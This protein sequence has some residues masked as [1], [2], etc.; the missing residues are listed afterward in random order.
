MSNYVLILAP[1]IILAAIITVIFGKIYDMVGFKR[2]VYPVVMILSAGYVVLALA[3][4]TVPVFIG[5]VLMMAGYLSGMAVF[6][7]KIRDTT[8]VD[9][10]GLFQGVRI[11]GQV[12]IPGIIGPAIGAFI[13]SDAEIIT[14][15]DGTTSFIPNSEIFAWA[16]VVAMGLVTILDMIFRMVQNEHRKLPTNFGRPDEK[17]P[18]PEYP[19][20]QLRRNSYYNLNGLWD[21]GIVVPFAPQSE[22]SGYKGMVGNTICYTRKFELPADF[23]QDKLLLHFGAVDQEAKVYVN[24]ELVG[25][26][27]GGYLP[28]E[29]DITDNYQAG[30]NEL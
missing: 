7:A 23:V 15:S 17:I 8:P 9:K 16:F 14:N 11:F 29:V 19:R 10:A 4:E 20:P 3:K 18:F 28:F 12:L 27:V 5:S 1:A 2:C 24:N 25:S 30:D 22:L 26:H 13:L 6:G 21:E